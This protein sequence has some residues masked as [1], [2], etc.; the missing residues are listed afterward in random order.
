MT[1]TENPNP[2]TTNEQKWAGAALTVTT[3]DEKTYR[4]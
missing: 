1:P 4:H 2:H 3:R